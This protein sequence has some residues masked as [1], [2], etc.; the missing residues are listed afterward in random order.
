MKKKCKPK[1][2]EMGGMNGGLMTPE[3][4]Q[5]LDPVA[6]QQY[7]ASLTPGERMK[8][9]FT[10]TLTAS[11]QGNRTATPLGGTN[12]E[13]VKNS[14]ES[15]R[16]DPD[17]AIKAIQPGATGSKDY[18][19]SDLLDRS[20]AE[21]EA[22]LN[23]LPPEERQAAARKAV[24]RKAVGQLKN[25]LTTL[26]GIAAS[27]T[28]MANMSDPSR[29]EA[30]T[31]AVTGAIQGAAGGAALGP[32]GMIGG[33]L[34]GGITGAL[35][36]G[37]QREAYEEQEK[38]RQ[39][40]LLKG[41]R[42]APSIQEK[43]GPI[44]NPEEAPERPVQT[45]KGEVMLFEDGRL[46]DVMADDTH[47]EMER[48]GEGDEVTD[49]IPTAFIFS[50]SKKRLIDLSKIKDDIF[51]ITRGV[52]SEDGNTPMEIV[53]VG[54]I[55][56]K[57]GKVT[58]AVL[59]KKIRKDLPIVEYPIEDIERRTNVEN[60]RQRAERL[61]VIMQ[62]QEG[63]YEKFQF[64]KPE[65]FEMGGLNTPCPDG[66]QKDADNRCFMTDP[67]TG[68]TVYY[69]ETLKEVVVTD[70][71]RAAFNPALP[72]KGVSVPSNTDDALGAIG[73]YRRAKN[74]IVPPVPPAGSTVTTPGAGSGNATSAYDSKIFDPYQKMLQNNDDRVNSDYSSSVANAEELFQKKRL[75]NL[76]ILG[77]KLGGNSMQEM[78]VTPVQE[79][80]SHVNDMFP[81]VTE[82]QIQSQTGELRKGQSRVLSAIGDSGIRGTDVGS[83]VASTQARLLEGEGAIRN[84]A[85]TKNQSQ[86]AL[87]A[88][89]L[90][91]IANTNAANE[92]GAENATR[93]NRNKMIS[94]IAGAGAEF[95]GA[96]SDLKSSISE[97]LAELKKWRQESR[98]TNE[99]KKLDLQIKKIEAGWKYADRELDRKY[100]QAAIDKMIESFG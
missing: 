44:V 46:V 27:F 1:K 86:A 88:A 52:Y 56:G 15:V 23:T 35:K 29:T 69:G 54:D 25:S 58:P 51:N 89:T 3:E 70:K 43:G 97:R 17:A 8:M 2:Y 18:V 73:A 91:R 37:T 14:Y 55:L 32:V 63:V 42:V 78:T 66:Y 45:E 99:Q 85:N 62:L 49:I 95:I 79:D 72:M 11:P 39:S 9:Q 77:A 12:L 98:D 31:G 61:K 64:E 48:E 5:A 80:A 47:K 76:A 65:K 71:G 21:Q 28:D 94:N 10:Q 92:V 26:S 30:G 19:P 24:D 40:G 60:L 67:E 4:F 20:P 84:S 96:Q 36:A 81:M 22:Y 13:P 38:R 50:N 82:S 16:T 74:P 41:L 100:K 57:K 75:S 7:L 93:S 53:K 90:N 6:Q 87:R 83:A 68:E 33:A 34:F 59:A